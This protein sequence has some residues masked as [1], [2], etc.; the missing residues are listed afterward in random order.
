M[1]PEVVGCRCEMVRVTA[2]VDAAKI[3]DD[4]NAAMWSRRPSRRRPGR[5][6]LRASA[7]LVLAC[8][9][10]VIVAASTTVQLTPS[11][12][13]RRLDTSA[14]A[15]YDGAL[16]ATEHVL[17]VVGQSGGWVSSVGTDAGLVYVGIGPRVAVLDATEVG[18]PP[19]LL[20][21]SGVLTDTVRDLVPVPAE[22]IAVAAGTAGLCVFDVVT[23]HSPVLTGC[24]DVGGA[25][26]E[27]IAREGVVFVGAGTKLQSVLLG[28]AGHT[29]PLGSFDLGTS[30]TEIT[31]LAI[32]GNRLIVA[33]GRMGLAILN[34]TDPGRPQVLEW[35]E[36][37]CR[38]VASFGETVAAIELVSK[39]EPGGGESFERHLVLLGSMTSSKMQEVGRLNLGQEGG[40]PLVPV[41]N[42]LYVTKDGRLQAIDVTDPT[43]PVEGESCPFMYDPFSDVVSESIHRVA[44]AGDR[45]FRAVNARGEHGSGIEVVDISR[46][47]YPR[48][49]TSWLADAPGNVTNI[50][51]FGS[52]IVV[53]ERDNGVRIIDASEPTSPVQVSAVHEDDSSTIM[54]VDL[55]VVDDQLYVLSPYEMVYRIDVSDP[56]VPRVASSAH[57]DGAASLA[58]TGPYL[59]VGTEQSFPRVP[60][61]LEVLDLQDGGQIRKIGEMGVGDDC[62]GVG[63]IAVDAGVAYLACTGKIAKIVTLTDPANPRLLSTIPLPGYALGIMAR[64]GYAYV[65]TRFPTAPENELV[66]LVENGVVVLDVGDGERPRVLGQWSGLTEEIR[67]YACTGTGSTWSIASW[68]NHLF[69]PTRAGSVRVIDIE[70]PTTPQQVEETT[71]SG[72]AFAVVAHEGYLYVAARSGG[73]YVFRIVSGAAH[74][75]PTSPT[76]PGT[77]TPSTGTPAGP[78]RTATAPQVTASPRGSPSAAPTDVSTR[79]STPDRPTAIPIQHRLFLPQML[80]SR[81]GRSRD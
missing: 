50:G 77:P 61:V 54:V 73:L 3:E 14:Q 59:V 62:R 45:M 16:P 41:D 43:A 63:D 23:P 72:F 4:P 13:L 55:A 66:G 57:V 7:R 81:V 35:M 42:V 31:G 25:A 75:T 70:D 20:A 71:I 29:V 40:G 21:I 5:P 28:D 18:A 76:G 51:A 52:L 22:R 68:S 56:M 19:Q 6:L 37:D 49:A 34:V 2:T 69:L 11:R 53:G 32:D 80:A 24:I 47:L 79:T 27:V 15:G 58:A 30:A 26:V 33:L 12:G 9:L 10:A 46:S 8:G 38:A 44:V 39:P 78:S 60:I 65:L 36:F 64:G 17:E 1:E 67:C 48:Q 74:P